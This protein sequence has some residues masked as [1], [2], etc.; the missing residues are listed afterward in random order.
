MM[1]NPNDDRESVLAALK[2]FQELGG[3]E[4]VH[5]MIELLRSQTRDQFLLV[6]EA[7]SKGD[8]STARRLAHSMKSS[9]GNFGAKRCQQLAS[10]MDLAGKELRWDDFRLSHQQLKIA[11]DQLQPLLQESLAT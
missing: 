3:K 2:Q 7:L 9:F 11:F 5:E 8:W 6:D 10:E 4:F 1:N